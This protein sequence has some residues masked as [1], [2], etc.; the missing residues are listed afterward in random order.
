MI[1]LISIILGPTIRRL[2]T[3]TAI[4][5]L[6]RIKILRSAVISSKLRLRRKFV[7]VWY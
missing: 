4:Y 3:Y 7:R 6:L 2:S 5:I 1:F